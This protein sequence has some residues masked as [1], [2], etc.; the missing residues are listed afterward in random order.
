MD[1]LSRI[2]RSFN[3][4]EIRIPKIFLSDIKN[5]IK[6]DKNKK[7]KNKMTR[8]TIDGN[9]LIYLENKN[10]GITIVNSTGFGKGTFVKN[11]KEKIIIK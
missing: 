1:L 3:T 5:E 7:Y 10:K 2:K 11:F 9:E 8:K 6:N 4:A